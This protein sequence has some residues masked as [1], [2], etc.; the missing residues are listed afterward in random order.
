MQ[1]PE[2]IHKVELLG[3]GELQFERKEDGLEV[4]LPD[5][6]PDLLYAYSLKIS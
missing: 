3:G 4:T 2:T 5:K 6:K 1:K